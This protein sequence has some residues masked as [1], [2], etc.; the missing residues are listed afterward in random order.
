MKKYTKR[1]TYTKR[2]PSIDRKHA[3]YR[4]FGG[5]DYFLWSLERTKKIA[6]FAAKR[7]RE[8]GRHS[9]VTKIKGGYLVHSRIKQK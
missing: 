1:R 8:R 7:Q 5:K 4:K 9:R 2:T 6:K 3:E